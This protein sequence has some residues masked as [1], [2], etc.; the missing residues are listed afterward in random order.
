MAERHLHSVD[1]ATGEI[2]PACPGC[3][4]RDFKIETLKTEKRGWQNRH[5]ELRR[6]LEIDARE[7]K[8]WP[9]AV[10]LFDF[11]R[12]RSGHLRSEWSPKRFWIA[13]PAG[14]CHDPFV[15][16]DREGREVRHDSWETLFRKT[17]SIEW[18]ANKAP[19][20]YAT[21]PRA[22]IEPLG[23][24]LGAFL[25]DRAPILQHEDDAVALARVVVELDR[26][27]REWMD[28]PMGEA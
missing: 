21:P 1:P 23:R 4:E 11:W 17:N 5:A 18:Y 28:Q 14:L 12:E 3:S 7:H 8:L 20:D 26:R 2:L 6:Q 19:R 9:R 16:K 25:A 24:A 22:G 10:R 27:I 13:A 15:T